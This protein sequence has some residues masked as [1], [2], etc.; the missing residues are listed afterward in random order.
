MSQQ[1][2]FAW[3]SLIARLLFFMG[4]AF[5]C[6]FLGLFVG[7]GGDFLSVMDKQSLIES[8]FY[9]A[10][11]SSLM[12]AV[13]TALVGE[14]FTK[15]LPAPVVEA[16]TAV[17]EPEQPKSLWSRISPTRRINDEV[18]KLRREI[19][20]LKEAGSAT[21]Q[22][23]W[24]ILKWRTRQ[25][26][27]LI[28]VVAVFVAIVFF[29]LR[30]AILIGIAAAWFYGGL[31]RVTIA[32]RFAL[33]T[34]FCFVL[35]LARANYLLDAVPD[36]RVEFRGG[37]SD[38]VVMLSSNRGTLLA[39]QPDRRVVFLPWDKVG[40]IEKLEGS[41]WT[42]HARRWLCNEYR[43]MTLEG[44]KFCAP[45]GPGVQPASARR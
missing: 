31:W 23:N 26:A 3:L 1:Q 6:F 11:L 7:I 32:R 14:G 40:S 30:N 33:A 37:T 22:Q 2:V 24:E 17:A 12:L 36:M 18:A 42:E 16:A 15:A 28:A 27:R 35:G 38:G 4:A 25:R 13:V 44:V 29:G 43:R 19:L 21:V 10:A 41:T 39:L 9:Y 20:A 45:T 5:S 8:A 34:L